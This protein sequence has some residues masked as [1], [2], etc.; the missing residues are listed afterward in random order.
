MQRHWEGVH[1]RDEI[2][3]SDRE[4]SSIAFLTR[5]DIDRCVWLSQS[6]PDLVP[7]APGTPREQMVAETKVR[8]KKSFSGSK[9]RTK[10]CY[11]SRC[12][13]DMV[14]SCGGPEFCDLLRFFSTL[15]LIK[16]C[17]FSVTF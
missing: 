11:S 17:S 15:V 7:S 13:D 14:P 6:R 8:R 1:I 5:Q 10:T 16:L 9:G 12:S 3:K 4:L 2:D